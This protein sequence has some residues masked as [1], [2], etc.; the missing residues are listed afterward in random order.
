MTAL[1]CSGRPP[2][3]AVTIVC[4]SQAQFSAEGPRPLSR[5]CRSDVGSRDRIKP[6]SMSPTSNL[7]GAQRLLLD[8]N[9]IRC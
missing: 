5:C 9:V 3:R 2:W 6:D 7:G 8:R 4:S 1:W